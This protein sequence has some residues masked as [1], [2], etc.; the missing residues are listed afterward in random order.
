MNFKEYLN[1]GI[2]SFLINFG[3]GKDLKPFKKDIFKD[4][5]SYSLYNAKGKEA[6]AVMISLKAAD[7]E[8]Y[9][10]KQFIVRS[11]IY[12]A[13][14]IRTMN[15]DVIVSPLSSSD[16]T[17]HFVNAI[18]ERLNI[19]VFVNSFKKQSDI[20][21]IKIDITH[22]NITD[23]IIK[24]MESIIE[25]GIRRNHLSVKMFLPQHRKFIKNMFEITDAKILNKVKD[26]NILIIDDIMTTGTSAANIYDILKTNDANN[27]NVLTIFKSS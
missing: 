9:E 5:T 3:K 20:S 24:S 16:L 4:F 14:I 8:S 1:N 21:K 22:P 26:K 25:R 10:V 7:F 19:D 12:A 13:R 17:K 2:G 27:I 18:N 23:V 15:I 11:S 6:N